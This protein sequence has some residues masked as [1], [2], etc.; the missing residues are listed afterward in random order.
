MEFIKTKNYEEMSNTASEFMFK[1]LV[2]NPNAVFCIATGYSPTETYRLFVE[3][4]KQNNIDTS[5]MKLVKLDEWCGLSPQ[6]PAT[7]DYYIEKNLIE[8]LS[9]SSEQYIA[10]NQNNYDESYECE[11]VNKLIQKNGGID[12]CILGIGRNGHLGL[13]EPANELNPFSHKTTLSSKTKQHSMLKS[14]NENVLEGYTL[15]IKDILDSKKVLLL[16]TGADKKE[17][18]Q[19]LQEHIISS[20]FPANYLWLHNDAKCIVDSDIFSY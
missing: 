12:C 16:I 1:C 3:K 19:K 18:Y 20:N 13:N 2:D 8:P 15:G 17:P 7:C 5:K 14:T 10:F 11:R 9:L 4:I 6:N